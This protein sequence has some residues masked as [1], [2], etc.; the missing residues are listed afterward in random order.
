MVKLLTKYH[1]FPLF[2]NPPNVVPMKPLSPLSLSDF[3]AQVVD[4]IEPPEVFGVC[5][6][7]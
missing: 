1:W 7:Q 6:Q 5:K 3:A 4:P 2:N